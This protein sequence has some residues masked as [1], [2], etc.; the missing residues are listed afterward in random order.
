MPGDSVAAG[1]PLIVLEAR[2]MQHAVLA[3]G[4]G[5][6]AEVRVKEGEQVAAG[7]VPA[8]LEAAVTETSDAS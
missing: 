5:V 1:R 8:M 3:P 2:K 6:V 4:V 7:Q